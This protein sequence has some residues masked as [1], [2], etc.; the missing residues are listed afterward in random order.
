MKSIILCA[1]YGTRL[2]PLTKDTPKALLPI[3]GKP[4]L[5]YICDKITSLDNVDEVFIV[6]NGRFFEQFKRWLNNYPASIPIRLVND[7]SRN[8]KDRLGAVGDL[9][10]VVKKYNINDDILVL[11]GDNLFD[12][13]LSEF[14]K[15]SLNI[16]P[17]PLIGIYNLKGS[18]IK[19][20]GVV[21]TDREGR[22]IDFY[23][24][25]S[26][27]NGSSLVSLCLYYLPK[28]IFS[29]LDEYINYTQHPTPKN[30]Y[31][32][33]STLHPNLD[34]I[35]NYIKWL[36]KNHKVYGYKFSGNW[37]D[38][39]DIDSYTEAVCSF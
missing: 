22:I 26:H 1:G 21:K 8:H 36:V 16:N 17:N 13:S 2:Y 24:K 11:G 9:A 14:I 18:R 5:E 6:V 10:L 27:L 39:G 12:F 29:S 34:S 20:Y 28:E 15:H 25:P 35:G 38:I 3:R 33:P 37:F 30:L 4:I 31:P 7:G 19:K 23:E 32:T